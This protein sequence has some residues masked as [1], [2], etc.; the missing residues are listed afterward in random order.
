MP[1]PSSHSTRGHSLI[2]PTS[3]GAHGTP[4]TALIYTTNSNSSP[5]RSVL[6]RSLSRSTS[7]LRSSTLYV[8]INKSLFQPRLLSQFSR[9]RA[10]KNKDKYFL[11]NPISTGSRNCHRHA[12]EWHHAHCGSDHRCQ[13]HP[14]DFP[15]A[16]SP[17]GPRYHARFNRHLGL[18]FFDPHER[19]SPKRRNRALYE[20]AGNQ[21][22]C[23]R[24]FQETSLVPLSRV[25]RSLP[26][27]A[28]PVRV[29]KRF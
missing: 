11:T 26:T 17:A 20:G 10:G 14:H 4:H 27:I 7:P 1:I 6:A 24:G 29:L 9:P 2:S 22:I 12:R 19:P 28:S 13:R 16:R 18:P 5:L 23:W 3:T 8:E 15:I 21:D 25:R